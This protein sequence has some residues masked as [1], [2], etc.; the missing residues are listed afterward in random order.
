MGGV[1]KGRDEGLG[2]GIFTGH[3]REE[4]PRAH[5]DL[6]GRRTRHDDPRRDIRLD[7]R[8]S[9]DSR[10]VAKR[11]SGKEGAARPNCHVPPDP[12]GLNRWATQMSRDGP[13]VHPLAAEVV[14]G[15]QDVA[16]V[17]NAAVVVKHDAAPATDHDAGV[18]VNVTAQAKRSAGCHDGA[19][20][21]DPAMIVKGDVLQADDGGVLRD[22]DAFANASET[23]APQLVRFVIPGSERVDLRSLIDGS[24]NREFA[25]SPEQLPSE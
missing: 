4:P 3:K 14:A 20:T 2:R 24:H 18:N 25:H 8:M 17:G 5:A 22:P 11:Y 19:V 9:A 6:P 23:E 12:D 16:S 13:I 1:H 21:V 15:R 7:E 10:P